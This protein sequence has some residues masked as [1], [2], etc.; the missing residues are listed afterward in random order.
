MI[1]YN[2]DQPATPP[3]E[4]SVS[5][6]ESEAAVDVESELAYAFLRLSYDRL[7]LFFISMRLM[8]DCSSLY[9]LFLSSPRILKYL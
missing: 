8:N 4:F 5:S 9:P 7:F 1:T 6:S 2:L 3:D